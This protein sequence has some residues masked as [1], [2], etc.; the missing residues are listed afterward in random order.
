MFNGKYDDIIGLIYDY[1]VVILD[2]EIEIYEKH[3]EM[4]YDG[5]PC[6]T[7]IPVSF[8]EKFHDMVNWETLSSNSNIPI[9]CIEKHLDEVD[10]NSL[11]RNS[12]IPISF[13]EK[14]L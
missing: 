1:A 8:F 11:S 10:W 9:C 5:L 2:V 14:H 12:N 13:F 6:N 4:S 3:K 7:N